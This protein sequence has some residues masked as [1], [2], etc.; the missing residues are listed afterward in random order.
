MPSEGLDWMAGEEL[1]TTNE[2]NRLITIA[3]TRLGIRE[4]R[5]TGGEPLLRRDLP[6]IIE[7]TS[8]LPP[9]PEI[10]MTTNGVGLAHRAAALAS[11]GLDRINVSLDTADRDTYAAITRRDYLPRVMAGLQAAAHAGIRSTRY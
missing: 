10:S 4:V 1:L 6:A 2:M 9:R 8:A 11:A 5:F 7:H 3:V